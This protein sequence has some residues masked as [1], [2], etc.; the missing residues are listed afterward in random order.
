MA[1]INFIEHI[2]LA[3]QDEQTAAARDAAADLLATGTLPTPVLRQIHHIAQQTQV[4][5]N[6]FLAHDSASSARMKDAA[7]AV[8]L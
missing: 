5:P 2:A 4:E 6:A 1:L 7:A 8:P 3:S